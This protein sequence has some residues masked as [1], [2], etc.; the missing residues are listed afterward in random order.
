MRGW[1]KVGLAL[2]FLTVCIACN[3]SQATLVSHRVSPWWQW[4]N[5]GYRTNIECGPRVLLEGAHAWTPNPGNTHALVYRGAEPRRIYIVDIAACRIASSHLF[6]QSGVPETAQW[7]A[8][9]TGVA[10]SGANGIYL[11]DQAHAFA[12]RRITSA[13]TPGVLYSSDHECTS[14]NGG[15]I[16]HERC[17]EPAWSPS[18]DRLIVWNRERISESPYAN[19]IAGVWSAREG[20]QTT[21]PLHAPD[22]AHQFL[23]AH[24][25]GESLSLRWCDSGEH[26]CLAA[27]RVLN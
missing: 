18:G 15:L 25:A 7:N 26:H 9:G 1:L 17:R 2:V 5:P 23:Y 6:E 11:L 27:V 3:R 24:W 21:E 19:E 14:T 10:F 16:V 12:P 22:E 8:Q 20:L 4:E 13:G